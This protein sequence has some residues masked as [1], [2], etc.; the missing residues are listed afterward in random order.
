MT[1]E[2]NPRTRA[3]YRRYGEVALTE[4]VRDNP[5]IRGFLDGY[6]GKDGL[7]F[8]ERT[9]MGKNQR[10]AYNQGFETGR[11]E[12][13][14]QDKILRVLLGEYSNGTKLPESIVELIELK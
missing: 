9:I 6:D 13:V 4:A 10:E 14:A 8:F 7:G 1:I 12:K 2:F 11:K 5:V 3:L